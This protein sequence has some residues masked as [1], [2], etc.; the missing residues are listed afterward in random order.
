MFQNCGFINVLNQMNIEWDI[1]KDYCSKF[2][3]FK[4][5][6]STA[7]CNIER[8][9]YE[10]HAYQDFDVYNKINDI[11]ALLIKKGLIE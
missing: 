5:E 1:L 2:E 3:D 4:E 8:L 10:H 9:K 7:L 6:E 11:I